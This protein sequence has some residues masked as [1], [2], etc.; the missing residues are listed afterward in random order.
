MR[1]VKN[2]LVILLSLLLM[3]GGSLLPMAAARIQ[4]NA[5]TNAVAYGNIEALQLKLEEEV[6]SMTYPEKMS[7]IINGMGME[8]GD[9]NTR[10]KN[11]DVP[12]AAYAA[13]TPYLELFLGKVPDND[14][15]QFY[16]VMVYD[17]TDPLRYAYYWHVS[18]SLD[19][20]AK[21]TMNMILDDE[22]GKLL[23]VELMDPGMS[24]ER[25]Y[26]EKLRTALSAI[27]LEELAL[28]PAEEWMLAAEEKYGIPAA[29]S[30]CLFADENGNEIF[31]EICVDEYGFHIWM[32]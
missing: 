31:I 13:L 18:L 9:E 8:V 6:L 17:E 32:I 27:Y 3:A 7:L 30:S 1:K 4:D 15:L 10:L 25:G 5:V 2:A 21:D 24:I 23:A 20:S 28:T 14:M 22:T 12:E 16:P 29:G 11:A 26:L 19:M